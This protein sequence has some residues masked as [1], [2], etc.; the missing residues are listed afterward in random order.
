MTLD[1]LRLEYDIVLS[2]DEVMDNYYEVLETAYN[3]WERHAYSTKLR[4][5]FKPYKA[6][7]Q[8]A[9]DA[10][11]LFAVFIRHKN[12]QQIVAAYVAVKQEFIFNP[13]FRM[14]SE[15]FWY[16]EESERQ[17][18]LSILLL[19]AVGDCLKEQNCEL[20]TCSIAHLDS[21]EVEITNK[22]IASLEKAGYNKTDTI[23]YKRI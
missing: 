21:E 4:I 12:T 19:T 6:A 3:W 17:K 7:F 13:S 2:T 10:K 14:A 22:K 16:V 20:M 9:A 18:H 23:L 8:A 5:P 11:S 1:E 15:L